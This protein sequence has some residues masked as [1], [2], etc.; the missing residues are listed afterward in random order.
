MHFATG[1]I[2]L[3][4]PPITL[5]NQGYSY[6]D[7]PLP[8]TPQHYH[9]ATHPTTSQ[10]L[11]HSSTLTIPSVGVQD[12]LV[13]STSIPPTPPPTLADQ[14]LRPHPARAQLTAP[15]LA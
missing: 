15:H 9:T 11:C 10:V 14:L 13:A 12:P 6:P 7:S 2:T 8:L 3:G 4:N 5:T 1:E